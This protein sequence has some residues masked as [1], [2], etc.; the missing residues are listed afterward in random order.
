MKKSHW[1][2]VVIIIAIVIGVAIGVYFS[3][4]PKSTDAEPK[5][6]QG[7]LDAINKKIKAIEDRISSEVKAL[8]LTSE[9]EL[10][11]NRK[12]D[13][14]CFSLGLVFWA[15]IFSIGYLFYYNGYDLL[16]SILNTAGLLS[17]MFPLWSILIW[18]SIS[19]DAAIE[20]SRNWVKK[21]LYKK[22]G[23]DAEVIPALNSSIAEN[24][25]ALSKLT[26]SSTDVGYSS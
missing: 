9:M 20:K 17:L 13:H 8:Q 7:K 15:A 16:T 11:L 6:D 5:S 14:I 10:A 25:E 24:K 18:K 26:S 19:F 21:W 23:H 22:Y 12:V 3:E 4:Q 1:I 2:I